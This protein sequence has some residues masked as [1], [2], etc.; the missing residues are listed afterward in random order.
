MG[1]SSSSSSKPG[2]L[3]RVKNAATTVNNTLKNAIDPLGVFHDKNTGSSTLT[4]V[5]NTLK[6][7]VDPLGIFHDKNSGKQTTTTQTTTQSQPQITDQT[8]NYTPQRRGPPP[9]MSDGPQRRQPRGMSN[10]NTYSPNAGHG[11]QR[12]EPQRRQQTY[13]TTSNA[14]SYAP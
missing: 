1:N 7:A 5:N 4:K 2:I 14:A 12:R 3:K 6:N 9:R 10:P 8:Q 13:R 11:P